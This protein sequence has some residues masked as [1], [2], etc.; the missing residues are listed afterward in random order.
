[1][2]GRIISQV[3]TYALHSSCEDSEKHYYYSFRYSLLV[4]MVTKLSWSRIPY[5]RVSEEMWQRWWCWGTRE[6][7]RDRREQSESS[8][9]LF[10]TPH[11]WEVRRRKEEKFQQ[12]FCV[13]FFFCHILYTREYSV[14]VSF[15]LSSFLM[16][17][18]VHAASLLFISLLSFVNPFSPRFWHQTVSVA[19]KA[20]CEY[21]SFLASW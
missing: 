18:I 5:L 15:S 20:H 7:E 11:Q 4:T 6:R 8:L 14:L 21:V 13:P 2:P 12:N 9:S 1:M 17:R 3:K 19:Y 10:S 16:Q